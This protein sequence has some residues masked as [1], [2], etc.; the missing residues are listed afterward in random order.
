MGD[1][2]NNILPAMNNIHNAILSAGLQDQIKVSTSVRLDVLSN[3]SPPSNSVI[4]V[5]YIGPIVQFLA[6]TGGPLLVNIYPYFSY[7]YSNGQVPLDFSLFTAPGT[8][9]YDNGYEYQ[10]L[11]DAMVD[12]LYYA[13]EK[14]GHS[15]VNVVVSESGWPSYGGVSTTVENAQIYNQNLISHVTDGTPKRPGSLE[16]YIFAMFMENLKTGDEVERNFGLFYPDQS[17]V[18]SVNF[19]NT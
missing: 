3:T 17:P 10:N 12:S 11:F 18:Y 6:N 2:A 4:A 1:Y 15:N 19:I 16:T 8:V 7:A 9:V 14:I 5:S 13:M